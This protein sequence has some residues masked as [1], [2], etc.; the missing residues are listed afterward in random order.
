MIGVTAGR[1]RL[2]SHDTGTAADGGAMTAFIESGDVDIEDGEN[3]MFVR[4]YVP[5]FKDLTG[6]ISMTFKAR[7]YPGGTQRSA[8]V[9]NV[10]STTTKVD[11]RVR[12]RQVA[13][14]MESNSST[15]SWRYGTL[16]I[17]AQPDGRR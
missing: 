8:S 16:R 6:S 9:S 3:I 11:T 4:K 1:S 15:S 2:Y 13:I 14:R 17:D 12:G 10:F 7:E 5:D